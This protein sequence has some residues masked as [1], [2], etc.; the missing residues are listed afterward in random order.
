MAPVQRRELIKVV[1]D[2]KEVRERA[3]RRTL[4]VVLISQILGGAGLAAGITVGALLAQDMMGSE[5]VAGLPTAVFTLGSALTAYLVGTTTQRWGRRRGLA[6][7]FMAGGVGGLG[8][9]A[10]AALDN[11]LLMFVM[12]FVYGA[13]HRL[14]ATTAVATIGIG[15][16]FM[17]PAQPATAAIRD[18]SAIPEAALTRPLGD[19]ATPSCPPPPK[20]QACQGE[21]VSAFDAAKGNFP[22]AVPGLGIPLG[23]VGAGNFMINQAGTFGPWNFGG[24]QGDSWETRILPQAAFHVREQVGSSPATIRTLATDGPQRTGTAGT[25]EQWSWGSPLPAWNKLGVGDADYATLYPFGWMTYKPFKTDVSM[26]FFSPI[27]AGEDRRTSLPVAYFDVRLANHTGQSSDVSVMFTMPNAP[28]HVTGTH[29]DPTVNTG[30]ESVRTG[31]RTR[32]QSANGVQSVTLSA[33]SPENT[34]DAE[35][36]EWTI[37]AKTAPG[38]KVSFVTSWN[39]D[40]DG[41]DIYAAFQDG[42]GLPNS[43]LDSSASAGAINVAAK[44]A[45]GEVVTIPFV[46]AWDF[47]QVGFAN[48]Q[49]VWMKRYTN[50]YGAQTTTANDYVPGSYPFH[51]SVNIA[52]D[53]L[54]EH[55]AALAAVE[56]WWSPL[57]T[58]PAYPKLMRT[59]ALNQLTTLMFNNTFW[60][61]G[62][63]RNSVQPDGFATAGPAQRLNAGRPDSHF[64]GIQDTG[65]GGLSGMGSTWDI[66]AYNYRIY[67]T[68]FPNLWRDTLSA[69]IEASLRSS[70]KNARDVYGNVPDG[71]PF[72]VWENAQDAPVQPGTDHRAPVPGVSQWLDSPS[73]FIMAWYAYAK[74]NNDTDLLREAWPAIKN[75][76]AFL[77]GTIPPGTSL[78]LDPGGFANIYNGVPQTGTGVYNSQLYLL[79]LTM[80]IAA[81]E[82]LGVEPL[83]VAGLRS[84][85]KAAK[86]QF[87]LTLWNPVEQFYR[88]SSAGPLTEHKL[89]DTFFAQHIAEDLG[90]PD[91]VDPERRRAHLMTNRDSALRYNNEGELL[92]LE[93]VSTSVANVG[94]LGGIWAPSAYMSASDYVLAA[95]RYNLPELREFGLTVAD[96]MSHQIWNEADNGFAFN[97]PQIWAADGTQNYTYPAYSQGLAVWDLMHA[98]KPLQRPVP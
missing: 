76:I 41:S 91:L 48:N 40:G 73:K 3:Q 9:V 13:G 63:V 7:G 20:S 21:E 6:L 22:L 88:I 14:V 26:R 37:A 5:G 16:A 84:D 94:G 11:V 70:N 31:F 19:I 32:Q 42:K 49:T 89:V 2:R 98:I 17:G 68:L 92:G 79:A 52:R 45:P 66:Q 28:G 54:L 71:D 86:L 43:A 74:I 39:A 90:L 36:S 80:A 78:P 85:L 29:T 56:K 34:P 82:Q 77:K 53:A 24:Q 23:G 65:A 18:Y 95:K 69:F 47:P 12:L 38:Q 75:Q 64:F 27:V 51:Q 57:A 87:E 10:A 60:E 72:I 50:F 58:D 25:V 4:T 93:A 81:G 97:A 46:M 35:K 59:A 44:L 61:G 67:F 62:L 8:V 1:G 55:D 83:Y 96:A 30:P 33:D 15:L